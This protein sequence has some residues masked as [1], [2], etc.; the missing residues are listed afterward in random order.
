MLDM[1]TILFYFPLCLYY[2]QA[3][4]WQLFCAAMPQWSLLLNKSRLLLFTGPL[5]PAQDLVLY[6]KFPLL[7][8]QDLVLYRKFRDKE[9]SSAARG[10]VGLFR[11]LN[12]AM[13]AKRDRGRGAD[14]GEQAARASLD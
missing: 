9:V 8:A 10:L 4:L 2:F 6:R 13:L 11:E 1:Q 5:L 12:P 14:L 3:A 7:P